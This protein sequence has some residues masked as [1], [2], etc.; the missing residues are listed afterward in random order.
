VI[1]Y[2][3]NAV[4]RA[5]DAGTSA[6]CRALDLPL[7]LTRVGK[8]TVLDGIS[9]E[10][11][12]RPQ[13]TEDN[14]TDPTLDH[15]PMPQNWDRDVLPAGACVFR[16]LGISAA[17][18]TNPNSIAVYHAPD[19]AGVSVSQASYYA[20]RWVQGID[21]C[22]WPVPG[23]PVATWGGD[24]G[25]WWYLS[26]QADATLMVMCAAAC[27]RFLRAPVTLELR[28]ANGPAQCE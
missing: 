15:V 26:E 23:C 7:D 28:L 19:D 1:T 18:Y 16:I 5:N 13:F 8:Q 11:I 14:R 6:E 9:V 22:D 2:V 25:Y 4:D 3:D 12:Q 27:E 21:L 20:R 24:G 10:V 17:C